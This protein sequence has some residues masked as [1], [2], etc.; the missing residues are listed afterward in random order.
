[1]YEHLNVH[2][3][4]FIVIRQVSHYLQ[5][6]EKAL[7]M[8]I[9]NFIE[10]ANYFLNQLTRERGPVSCMSDFKFSALK[11]DSDIPLYKQLT[12]QIRNAI[13]MNLFESDEPLPKEMD[14]SKSLNISR[15]VVRQAI[16]QLVNEGILYRVPGKGTFIS[17]PSFEYD[18]LG[19]Y[20]FRDEINRQGLELS[21]RFESFAKIPIDIFNASMFRVREDDH[22]LEIYRTLLVN[23]SPVILEKTTIPDSF[24]PNLQENDVKEGPFMKVFQRHNLA[25]HKAKKYIEPQVADPFISEKLGINLG[26]PVLEIDRYTYGP[27]NNLIARCEWTVR[28]DQCRHFINLDTFNI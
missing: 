23:E 22:L 4:S 7:I 9:N 14:I 16:L 18:L 20:N 17:N 1:M 6:N 24:V 2:V 5:I 21:I 25:L 27:E 10:F 11:H 28:G 15:S 26:M 8:D 13:K 3:C 12:D 19:F